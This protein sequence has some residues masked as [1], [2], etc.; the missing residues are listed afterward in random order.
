MEHN[1]ST[2]RFL[3]MV[4]STI[5]GISTEDASVEMRVLNTMYYYRLLSFVSGQTLCI[6]VVSDLEIV[7]LGLFSSIRVCDFSPVFS[8][9]R[10]LGEG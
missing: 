1:H 7:Y 6:C 2:C 9:Y 4:S 10:E 3:F 8:E 5:K